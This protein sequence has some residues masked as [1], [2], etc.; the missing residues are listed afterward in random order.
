[1]KYISSITALA[2]FCVMMGT[3]CSKETNNYNDND[4]DNDERTA[5]RL[6]SSV[7]LGTLRLQ[8]TQIARGQALSF[9]VTTSGNVESVLYDNV[10]IIANGSGAFTYEETMYY[11]TDGSNVDFYAVH[12][13]SEDALMNEVLPFS[14]LA[15]QSEET[16][17][18]DSDL[19]YALRE[20]V[21]RTVAPVSMTFYHKMAKLEFIIIQGDGADISGL[22]AV[23]TLNARP[24]TTIDLTTGTLGNASGTATEII[25][26][27]V[28]NPVVGENGELQ[29]ITSI[30]VPQTLPAG[31]TFRIRLGN[32]D[33][34]YTTSDTGLT[35]E[36]GKKYTLRLTI[37]QAEINLRSSIE[38]WIEGGTITGDG[39]IE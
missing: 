32:I 2:A 11:P 39:S 28:D 13:Y 23:A 31:R 14:I 20:N 16:N 26:Y 5:I 10:E 21:T 38:D 18:L 6:S 24:S 33:Y 37:N 36:A 27:G 34:Y 22:N 4:N 9:F 1:M 15:D 19:L 12:P 7:E 25:S 29:G 30:I 17:Y 35:F 8:D 3:S